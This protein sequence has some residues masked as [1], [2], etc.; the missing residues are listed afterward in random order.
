MT[1]RPVLWPFLQP[2][3]GQALFCRSFHLFSGKLLANHIS[4]RDTVK[5]SILEICVSIRKET[6]SFLKAL[7][8]EPVYYDSK[9]DCKLLLE[10]R[11]QKA[12]NGLVTL[13]EIAPDFL[14]N[15][16]VSLGKTLPFY[17]T[18]ARMVY[19]F[20][21]NGEIAAAAALSGY[22]SMCYGKRSGFPEGKLGTIESYPGSVMSKMEEM[23]DRCPFIGAG[24]FALSSESLDIWPR[25]TAKQR[26]QEDLASVFLHFKH[27]MAPFGMI[28]I[29]PAGDSSWLTQKIDLQHVASE[30]GL[31]LTKADQF[32]RIRL[33]WIPPVPRVQGTPLFN[34]EAFASFVTK[35]GRSSFS[36][37]WRSILADTPQKAIT[38]SSRL[39]PVRRSRTLTIAGLLEKSESK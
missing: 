25:E 9:E 4:D 7:A 12:E 32:G 23:R 18:S 2:M 17:S 8:K 29:L 34:G 22:F 35:N 20:D 26:I 5:D 39:A 31:Q 13:S 30:S 37:L 33:D 28:L 27:F 16:P 14:S 3:S 1:Q 24:M 36:K 19:E 11:L 10:S 15:S 38:M 6:K 21:L